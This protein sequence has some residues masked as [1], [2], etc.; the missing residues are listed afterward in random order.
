MPTAAKVK[1]FR[2][3]VERRIATRKPAAYLLKEAWLGEH[4]FY[5]DERVIVP[6]SFIAEWL[7][8]RRWDEPPIF[9]GTRI[10]A[11][12]SSAL[13]LCTG[14][15]C[16][17]ILM[18]LTFPEAQVDAADISADA[19]DVAK[20][21][22]TDYGSRSRVRLVRSNMFAALARAHATTSSSRTRRT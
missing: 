6:R 3:L 12:C 5:V 10:A 19:L 21:N 15:G 18:A 1:A 20:R 14:S 7:Q 13:D 9:F 22:V 17:A 4:R 8:P 2:A 16:L 11:T